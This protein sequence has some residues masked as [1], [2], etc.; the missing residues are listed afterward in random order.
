M[1]QIYKFVENDYV[2]MIENN[3]NLCWTLIL[4]ERQ[5]IKIEIYNTI[6]M[7]RLLNTK[8]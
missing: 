6:D 2:K 4:T 3:V 1:N 8:I 7:K 5:F